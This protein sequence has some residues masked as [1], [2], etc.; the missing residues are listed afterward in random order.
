MKPI[1]KELFV[2]G[3]QLRF[4]RTP[5]V[6]PEGQAAVREFRVEAP[7]GYQSQNQGAAGLANQQGTI[8][9]IIQY[10]TTAGE[11]AQGRRSACQACKHWDNAAWQ[12][13]ITASTGPLARAED[14]QTLESLRNTLTLRGIQ[15]AHPNGKPMTLDE[16]VAAHGICRVL[17][18][19]VEGVVGRDPLH[20]PVV[21]GPDA[22]CLARETKFIT[23]E[24]VKSFLDFVGGERISVLTH[25]G[26]W[27][28]ATV[29]AYG[30]QALLEIRF[31][32][33]GNNHNVRATA[34]HRWLL[35]DGST[36]ATKDL[37]VGQKLLKPPHIVRDWAFD[38]APED[39]Q[40]AWMMGFVFGDGSSAT[41]HGREIGSRVRLCGHK[42]KFVERFE[43]LGFRPTYPE[44]SNGE[45]NF[46]FAGLMKRLPS[47]DIGVQRLTGFVRGLLDADGWKCRRS[48]EVDV[49]P[50]QGIQVTGEEVVGFI[51]R[52]FPMVGAYIVKETEVTDPT[53]FGER[54][55]R[56]VF[57]S[58]V[59][60][61][62]TGP[63]APY[64]VRAVSAPVAQDEVW[65]LEV[66]GDES[67]VLPQGIVTRNCPPSCHAGASKIDVATPAAPLGFFQPR[68]LDAVK[69]GDKRYDEVLRLAQGK[70]VT[71]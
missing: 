17:S 27:R 24:G 70:T 37:I 53:N 64:S 61:F 71:K 29:K 21:P 67:F 28:A 66:E 12:K 7:A 65:C 43:H 39:E 20:W 44:S 16:I 8:P 10:G 38:E 40:R 59:L 9:A 1:K 69:I 19:W 5:Q 33:A 26:N 18:D 55:A 34:E 14:K 31:G 45:P 11:L 51:Q 2:T 13:F 50:F 57:F 30:R 62:S 56:T 22:N 15:Y 60:G 54:S 63:M 35:N 52:V 46:Y 42:Q 23:S 6:D 4:S 36:V 49:N 48:S 25:T 58:L 47:L 41:S 32:R 3:Q 68:D